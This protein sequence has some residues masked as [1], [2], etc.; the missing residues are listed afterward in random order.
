MYYP[1]KL[2]FVK[3]DRVIANKF[4]PRHRE[5]REFAPTFSRQEKHREFCCSTGKSL[6][7][8]ENILT[9]IINIKSI[10]LF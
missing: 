4:W 9:D 10:F 6:E 3:D 5:N 1:V 8:Q 7:T 2:V